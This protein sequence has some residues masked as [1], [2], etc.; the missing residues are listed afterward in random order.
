M[1]QRGYL[2]IAGTAVKL[3]KHEGFV[4]GNRSRMGD[5]RSQ[6]TH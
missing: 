2:R 5:V 3:G 4:P 1:N 6:S